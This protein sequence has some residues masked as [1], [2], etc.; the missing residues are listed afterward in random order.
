MNQ[1]VDAEEEGG[2]EGEMACTA[3]VRPVDD[4][5]E[6]LPHLPS[7]DSN[8]VSSTVP[9]GPFDDLENE[10]DCI[11][12]AEEMAPNFNAL[13][14]SDD[15]IANFV[16]PV[17]EG[18]EEHPSMQIPRPRYS[19]YHLTDSDDEPQKPESDNEA[20]FLKEEE[21][22]PHE[23]DLN[24]KRP[25]KKHVCHLICLNLSSVYRIFII[26]SQDLCN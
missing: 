13:F 24:T 14:K 25:A 18:K 16:E 23:C 8:I 1:F 19:L 17:Q 22:N 26:P 10:T 5:N 21:G 20:W 9:L 12:P 15:E 6:Y 7:S 2:R 11:N 4:P 3:V